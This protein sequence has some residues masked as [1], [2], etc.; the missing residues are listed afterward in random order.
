MIKG[1]VKFLLILLFLNL[2][3]I[4]VN[5]MGAFKGE[6]K[7]YIEM[8]LSTLQGNPFIGL[9]IGILATSIMQSSSATTSIVVSF[10]ALGFFGA[11][12]EQALYGAIPVVMG[13]NIGT[14][15]TSVLVA[16]GH[17][18]DRQEFK[19]AFSA[20]LVHDLFNLITV[21]ILFPIQ[22]YT[23]FLGKLA[24]WMTS[25]FSTIGGM[26]FSGPLEILVKPQTKF[27][28]GMFENHAFLPKAVLFLVAAFI[29]VILLNFMIKESLTLSKRAKYFIILNSFYLGAVVF[30]FSEY[31]Q[32][33]FTNNVSIFAMALT[34]LFIALGGFVNTMKSITSSKMEMVFS[35][36]IFKNAAT[37][38]VMGIIFTVIVQSSSVSISVMIPLAGAGI[39]NACQ[40]FPYTMGANI[41]TTITSMLAALSIGEF[42]GV[43]I[44]FAHLSF[45]VLGVTFIFPVRHIPVRIAEYFAEISLKN[46]L[47]PFIFILFIYIILP[48]LGIML[49]RH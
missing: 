46:R 49:F 44:A 14:S 3:F 43:A 36:Y 48:F 12:T 5:L 27:I 20:A 38:F 18:G 39:L 17:I 16:F 9:M 4:S 28:L 47:V 13:A 6:A 24:M 22:I 42:A 35:R 32:N 19:R 29:F 15:I 8:L 25:I 40:L 33:I 45:N 1:F 21:T 23:N 11:S 7:V 34:I 31:P 37:A 30:L 41:G 2:F 10:V 26:K